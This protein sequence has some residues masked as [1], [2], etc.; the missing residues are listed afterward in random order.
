MAFYYS[1]GFSMR[2]THDSTLC[3]SGIDSPDLRSVFLLSHTQFS[4]V[5][6]RSFIV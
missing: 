3:I 1:V 2:Y 4:F 6:N 5:N